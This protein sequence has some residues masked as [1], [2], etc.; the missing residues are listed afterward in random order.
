MN[1]NDLE[2]IHEAHDLAELYFPTD[3][4][5]EGQKEYLLIARLSKAL[6]ERNTELALLRTTERSGAELT[7]IA[8]SQERFV[9]QSKLARIRAITLDKATPQNLALAQEI[10]A[11][12]EEGDE[13]AYV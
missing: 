13:D 3:D 9:A 4:D 2:L 5:A 11:I 7:A 8:A 12:V 1:K 6:L 10:R